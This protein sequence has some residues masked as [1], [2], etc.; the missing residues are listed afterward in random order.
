M[1]GSGRVGPGRAIG[2]HPDRFCAERTLDVALAGHDIGQVR[3]RN[4]SSATRMRSARRWARVSAVS[5]SCGTARARRA[6]RGRPVRSCSW[7]AAVVGW[8][9]QTVW[10]RLAADKPA[11]MAHGNSKAAT[12]CSIQPGRARKCKGS[13]GLKARYRGSRL[14]KAAADPRCPRSIGQLPCAAPRGSGNQEQ[15]TS[16]CLRRPGSWRVCNR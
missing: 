6:I 10:R 8:G 1:T 2:Q 13:H 9:R 5:G 12:S 7:L 16:N 14:Y 15:R 3:V 4:G 11:W